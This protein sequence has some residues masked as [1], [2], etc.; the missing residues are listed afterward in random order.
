MSDDF[1]RAVVWAYKRIDL[2]K[3]SFCYGESSSRS[4]ALGLYEKDFNWR[5]ELKNSKSDYD[6]FDRTK[7]YCAQLIRQ[8]KTLPEELRFFISNYLDDILSPPVKKR[9]PLKKGK[10]TNMFLPQLV[11]SISVNF[12]LSPTRNSE[13]EHKNS[14]CDTVS[15]AINTLPNPKP[16]MLKANSYESLSKH[17]TRAKKQG[18]LVSK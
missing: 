17:Y 16:E 15:E 11:H 14:A 9:G 8:K 10:E 4:S 7:R 3:N 13:S 2:F 5:K 18:S 1:K 12:N 6:S